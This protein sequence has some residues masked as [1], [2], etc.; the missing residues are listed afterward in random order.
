LFFTGYTRSAGE[1]L[2]EQDIKSKMHDA[3]MIANLHF[4]KQ[5]GRD[6]K[7][8]LEAGHLD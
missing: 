4:V 7:E 1:I 3:S 5:I 6:S 8:A 2:K